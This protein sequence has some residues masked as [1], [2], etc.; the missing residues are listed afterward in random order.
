M[1][2]HRDPTESSS[3]ARHVSFSDLVF[4]IG[5]PDN[6]E[7]DEGPPI[8][9]EILDESD[10]TLSFSELSKSEILVDSNEYST[11][12]A[13]EYDFGDGLQSYSNLSFDDA[14]ASEESMLNDDDGVIREYRDAPLVS[15]AIASDDE[16]SHDSVDKPDSGGL[17]SALFSSLWY[18]S[19]IA[20]LSGI[21]A[22]LV[23]CCCSQPAAPVDQDDVA[24]AAGAASSAD[25]GFIVP[26][27]AGDGGTTFIT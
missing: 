24:A 6:G 17:T 27:F 9:Q 10:S 21:F 14:S 1:S 3:G 8:L 7:Y 23:S 4:V 26:S 12:G 13:G 2:E 22:C 11:I 19:I 25:K 20:S 18:I 5:A 16:E 15:A